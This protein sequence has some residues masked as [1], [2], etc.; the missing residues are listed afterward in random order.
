MDILKLATD[1][2]KAELFSSKFFIVFA[3]LFII[4]AIVFYQ[5]GKTE[6]ARAFVTPTLVT[7]ILLLI[8]GGGLLYSN[9]KRINEFPV[10][11]EADAA[12]FV[13]SEIE[14]AE[15]TIK[16]FGNVF[17][18]IPAIV[19]I[20]ALLIIFIDKPV[21]KAAYIATIAMMVVIMAVDINSK[22]RMEQYHKSLI[23]SSTLP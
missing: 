17:K 12:N 22:A 3:I 11:Y 16:E 5:L 7:G 15:K 2:A 21:W 8:V 23:E 10:Q 14:R 9:Q 13:Q 6:M 18:V 4:V 1:W 19:A 20:C